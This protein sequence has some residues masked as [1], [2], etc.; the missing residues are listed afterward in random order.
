MQFKVKGE[1]VLKVPELEEYFIAL[2]I[3]VIK[4]RK[5]KVEDTEKKN[6]S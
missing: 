5:K 4:K 6:K 2:C 1:I 3:G